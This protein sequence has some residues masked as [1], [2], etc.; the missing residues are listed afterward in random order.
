M[1]LDARKSVLESA[2]Q[3]AHMRSLI[4]AFVIHVLE[5]T[6]SKLALSEISIF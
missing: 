6:F 4:S 3:P 1:G 2:D 5:S